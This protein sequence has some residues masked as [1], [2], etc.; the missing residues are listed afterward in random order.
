MAKDLVIVES[1]AKAR[2]VGR[3]LGNKYVAK[4]KDLCEEG[5]IAL[6]NTR[7]DLNKQADI[8]K[9]GGDITEDD[10]RKLHD[11]IQGMLKEFEG[12]VDGLQE[13]KSA[14]ILEV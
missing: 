14:E 7:R 4:V 2:T 5:R 3:F 12:K 13:K 9:K 10:N 11:E 8:L 1:P 6:R